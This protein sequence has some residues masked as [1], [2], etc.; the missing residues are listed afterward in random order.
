MAGDEKKNIHKLF[1]EYSSDHDKTSG[2]TLLP[3]R[4]F[5]R[6]FVHNRI[7]W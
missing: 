2:E 1:K 3:V 5:V 4:I 6:I 7:N